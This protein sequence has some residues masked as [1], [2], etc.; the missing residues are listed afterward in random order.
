MK[1]LPNKYEIVNAA[2]N[3]ALFTVGAATVN[4]ATKKKL[5][6]KDLGVPTN[7]MAVAKL[8]A[9]IGVGSVLIAYLRKNDPFKGLIPD[10]IWSKSSS[11]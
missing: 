9:T 4:F 3:G 7:P 6:K 2:Y 8:A 10:E 11:G 5:A 1:E